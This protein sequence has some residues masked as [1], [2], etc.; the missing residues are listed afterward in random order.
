MTEQ[1]TKERKKLDV[2]VVE[3]AEETQLRLEKAARDDQI[4]VDV[5]AIQAAFLCTDC[6]KQYK[7]VTEMEN[8]LS[9][10]DHHHRKRLLELKK[11][12][13]SAHAQDAKRKREQQ[14]EAAMLQKRIELA[15]AAATAS[16]S[17][18]ARPPVVESD[19]LGKAS[20]P[21]AVPAKVGFS[22]GAKVG[23]PGAFLGKK[24]QKQAL[25]PVASAFANPFQERHDD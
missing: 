21:Q 17:V 18:S 8:H 15:A 12:S 2:E 19:G 5:K 14:H 25:N 3:T 4:K 11:Q 7:T 13:V 23:K 16:A 9:S 10:Y 22:F 24:P 6:Q 20:L 1:A